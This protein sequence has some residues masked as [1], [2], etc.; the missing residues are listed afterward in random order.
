MT[1]RRVAAGLVA[2]AL[3]SIVL[4]LVAAPAFE[5]AGTAVGGTGAVS[6]AWPAHAAGDIA[7]LFVPPMYM[8]QAGIGDLSANRW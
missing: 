6:P 7:L 1:A 4:P 5:A 3:G 8:A 2:L